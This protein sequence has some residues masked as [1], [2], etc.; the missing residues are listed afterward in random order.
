MLGKRHHLTEVKTYS[1]LR[2][3]TQ[4]TNLEEVREER[5]YRLGRSGNWKASILGDMLVEL[6][7]SDQLHWIVIPVGISIYLD[8]GRTAKI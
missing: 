3:I 1:L 7:E 6:A 4:L 5:P 2:T 8:L